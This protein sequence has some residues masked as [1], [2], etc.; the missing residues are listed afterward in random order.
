MYFLNCHAQ[1]VF[2]HLQL[3]NPK[4]FVLLLSFQ[5]ELKHA[6]STSLRDG[7]ERV[8]CWTQSVQSPWRCR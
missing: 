7:F 1:Y 3:V 4:S 8:V 5:Q 2:E 6:I